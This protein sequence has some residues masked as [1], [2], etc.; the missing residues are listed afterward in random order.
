ML[1]KKIYPYNGRCT[2]FANLFDEIRFTFVSQNRKNRDSL[3]SDGDNN[4]V[5]ECRSKIFLNLFVK[6]EEE[7]FCSEAQQRECAGRLMN[8]PI[9]QLRNCP[10]GFAIEKE[11]S[12]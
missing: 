3:G 1:T 8:M 9:L 10:G 2:F 4:V 5:L 12:L 7:S 6:I 11:P